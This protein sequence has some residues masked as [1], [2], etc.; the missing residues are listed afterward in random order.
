MD[1]TCDDHKG[2]PVFLARNNW[3][4]DHT[5]EECPEIKFLKVKE[6]SN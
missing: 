6:N 3:H 2:N 5:K 1:A 4:L